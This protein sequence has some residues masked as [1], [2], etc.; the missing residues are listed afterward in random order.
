M[1]KIFDVEKI[2][3]IFCSYRLNYACGVWENIFQLYQFKDFRFRL[4]EI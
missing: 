1:V 2:L 4:H 3:Y